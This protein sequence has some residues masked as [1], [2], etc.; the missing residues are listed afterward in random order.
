MW[1]RHFIVC[2]LAWVIGCLVAGCGTSVQRRGT[3]QLLLSD[4]VDR[5]IDQLDMSPLV[6]RRVYLDTEYM[7]A[8]KSSS[9]VNAEYITSALR[10]KMTTSGCLIQPTRTDADYVLE[11]RIGALGSD[12]MEVTYGIP[13]SNGVSQAASLVAG[14]QGIPAIPEIS[15]GKRSGG[16]GIAKVMV[17]AYHRDTGTPVLQSGNAIARSDAKDSWILGFG[18]ISRGSV[19][20]ETRIAGNRLR[21]PFLKKRAGARRTGDLTIRDHHQFVHPAVLERQLADAAAAES[22]VQ[23][24]GHEEEHDNAAANP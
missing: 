14:A 18:P 17:F 1:S 16:I 8:I 19:Y 20:D 21:L 4:A 2:C 5:A 6:G 22:D 12:S 10:Q 3:E 23:T 11:A 9:F 13:S 15:V 7:R 24:A